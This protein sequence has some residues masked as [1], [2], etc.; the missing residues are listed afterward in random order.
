MYMGLWARCKSL[1]DSALH[2]KKMEREMEDE[3]R[4]HV[5][6]Y[7]EDLVRSGILQEQAI[8]MARIEFGAA[9]TVKDECRQALGLRAWDE[10][11]QDLQYSTRMLRKHPGF[12][13]IAILNLALGIGVN[14]TVFS[15]INR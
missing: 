10:L 7:V 4:F 9:E 3:L 5:A 12:A 2:R 6:R 11:R 13:A 14:S 8:R 1:V 15:I